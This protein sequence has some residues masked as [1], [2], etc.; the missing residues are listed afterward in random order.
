MNQEQARS[1]LLTHSKSERN[2]VF[3]AVVSFS[4]KITNP[5]CGD[6]VELQ[7]QTEGERIIELGFK[8]RACAICS[9]SSSLLSE[10]AKGLKISELLELSHHFE[11]IL[12]ASLETP[13]PATLQN[14]SCFEHLRVNPARKACALLPWVAFRSALK[15]QPTSQQ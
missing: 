7:I 12:L 13:W 6:H 15:S 14:F 8:A 10:K 1:I 4:S 3:P 5:I 9:A 11:T 2:G